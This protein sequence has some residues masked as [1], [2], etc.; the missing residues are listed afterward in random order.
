MEFIMA[1]RTLSAAES[2]RKVIARQQMGNLSCFNVAKEHG[3]YVLR[4]DPEAYSAYISKNGLGACVT[5]P[6]AT[7]R[8][9]AIGWTAAQRKK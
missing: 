5:P 1:F 6:V 7:L 2:F 3:A 9:F 4:F 8:G